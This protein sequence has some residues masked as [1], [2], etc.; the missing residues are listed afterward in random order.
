MEPSNKHKEIY[1][2]W[3]DALHAYPPT[4][5][6]WELNDHGDPRE[7]RNMMSNYEEEARRVHYSP[8]ATTLFGCIKYKFN[9]FKLDDEE[10]LEESYSKVC[11]YFIRRNQPVLDRQNLDPWNRKFPCFIV[12]KEDKSIQKQISNFKREDYQPY[13]TMYTAGDFRM[14]RGDVIHMTSV[15][16][17]RVYCV[18]KYFPTIFDYANINKYKF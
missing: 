11:S 1:S 4:N 15:K 13:W 7:L 9:G 10:S 8:Q 14:E 2:E 16:Q 3:C 12:G 6:D 5:P 17:I 18:D